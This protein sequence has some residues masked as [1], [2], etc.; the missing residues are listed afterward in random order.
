MLKEPD[1]KESLLS[2]LS[3]DVMPG[4]MSDVG[5][6]DPKLIN[7]IEVPSQV[8]NMMKMMGFGQESSDEILNI[9]TSG[10]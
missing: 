3:G 10:K 9:L 2:I 4:M 7:N 6:S 5:S 1:G 8:T